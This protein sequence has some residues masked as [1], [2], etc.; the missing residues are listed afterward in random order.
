MKT[1]LYICNPLAYKECQKDMCYLYGGE[2]R[3]TTKKE[4]AMDPN[5]PDCYIEEGEDDAKV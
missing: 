1:P 4:Y 5:E 3:R 2:C